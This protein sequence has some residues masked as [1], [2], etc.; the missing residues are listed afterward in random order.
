MLERQIERKLKIAVEK[1][2]GMCLKF[3]SPGNR[4]VPDRILLLPGGLVYFVELKSETGKPFGLQE[5]MAARIKGLGCRHLFLVGEAGLN[6]VIEQ[7]KSDLREVV[8]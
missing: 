1:L 5:Y 3:T 2:D 4:G 8:S 6:A 7:F